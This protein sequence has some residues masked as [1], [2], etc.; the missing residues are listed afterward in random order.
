M[1]KRKFAK[2]FFYFL[3]IYRKSKK[4]KVKLIL[5]N[6]FHRENIF[7]KY[8][9]VIKNS[10]I[11]FKNIKNF[12]LK[13][14]VILIPKIIQGKLF[15]ENNRNLIINNKKKLY[16]QKK[17]KFSYA[18]WFF[19]NVPIWE[20]FLDKINNINYLEIG[21]FE[22]RSTVFVGELKKCNSVTAVDTWEGSGNEHIGISFIK[23]FKNFKNNISS[24]KK[25]VKFFK[26]TS[27]NFFKKNKNIYNLI[28]I[29][30]SHE[31]SQ[32]KKIFK[33]LLIVLKKTGT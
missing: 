19:Y 21:S 17:Y 1:D 3:I 5:L 16:F 12:S 15:Y 30:G 4:N 23:V 24:I 7:I 27:D 26:G 28:Y 13:Y 33:T 20:K 11:L 9:A 2:I 22:G 6:F 10:Y 14:S 32:V 29:D 18:D 25:N 31:Y 8:L